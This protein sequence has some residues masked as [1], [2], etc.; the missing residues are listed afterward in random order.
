MRGVGKKIRCDMTESSDGLVPKKECLT[1]QLEILKEEIRTIN[2][3]VARMDTITQ[4][5]KNWAIVTWTASIGFILSQPKLSIFV[6]GTAVLPLVFWVLDATWRRLQRRSTFRS[7]QVS[8]FLNDGRLAR[9]YAARQLVDFKVFDP[10]GTS[11]KADV[12]YRRHISL[13]QTLL[14][15]EVYVVYLMQILISILLGMLIWLLP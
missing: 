10:T 8:A 1:Y 6:A 11:H 5:T 7:Q 14:Y 4:A 15:P 9:S 13:R 3:I 12:A 2:G